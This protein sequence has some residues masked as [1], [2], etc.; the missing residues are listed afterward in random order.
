MVPVQA[1]S[2]AGTPSAHPS[3]D[4]LPPSGTQRRART[5]RPVLTRRVSQTGSSDRLWATMS[6]RTMAAASAGLPSA[7]KPSVAF[8]RTV[9]PRGL[10]LSPPPSP[11]MSGA[12]HTP[13]S[14]KAGHSASRPGSAYSKKSSARSST[15][16]RAT[17]PAAAAVY[18]A[19]SGSMGPSGGGSQVS[20][21]GVE[22]GP[23]GARLGASVT[24]PLRPDPLLLSPSNLPRRPSF[25]S[26]AASTPSAQRRSGGGPPS[27]IPWSPTPSPSS[28]QRSVYTAP[29][30]S[31][32]IGD[33][34]QRVT[35]CDP[36][37]LTQA[38]KLYMPA[39]N[40]SCLI[41]QGRQ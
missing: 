7:R 31:P 12:L 35:Q 34:L 14:A 25:A 6:P 16:S 26:P 28:A 1:I 24:A 41:G 39:C 27:R 17:P 36:S 13:G 33:G 21:G 20:G 3:A 23:L 37:T 4:R 2:D 10:T 22:L 19:A 40:T 30:L 8:G 32:R 15:A 18:R 11:S 9:S 29:S 38:Q 5:P